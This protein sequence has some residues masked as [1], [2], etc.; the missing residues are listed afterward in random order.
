MAMRLTEGLQN[1]GVRPP[2]STAIDASALLRA[3]ESETASAAE[4]RGT[5]ARA[6]SGVLSAAVALTDPAVV[7]VGVPGA[8]SGG[9]RSSGHEFA[10]APHNVSVEA[11]T[12]ADE[13]SFA[14]ARETAL[15]HL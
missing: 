6:V 15:Q 2:G 3:V 12:V 4:L 8:P 13:P 1:L 9:A 7:F 11:A 10:Q 14:G 5:L